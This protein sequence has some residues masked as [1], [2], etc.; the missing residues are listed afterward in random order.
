MNANRTGNG[1]AAAENQR[2]NVQDPDEDN[3]FQFHHSGENA[4]KDF[5]ETLKYI[6]ILKLVK[7]N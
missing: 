2:Q 7:V 5:E 1:I 3:Y 6:A 4:G